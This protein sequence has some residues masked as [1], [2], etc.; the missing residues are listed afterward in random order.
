MPSHPGADTG[1]PAP[2]FL[3]LGPV[4]IYGDDGTPVPVGPPLQRRVLATLILFAGQPCT[5]R[6]L[7]RAIWGERPP[8]DPGGTLRKVAYRLRQSLGPSAS[9]LE[10]PDDGYSYKFSAAK[11]ATDKGQFEDLARRGREAWYQDDFQ[12]AAELLAAAVRLWRDPALADVPATPALVKTGA[13]QR[14]L[15]ARDDVADLWMDARLALGGHHEAIT[16]LRELLDRDPLREHSWAQLITALYRD[17]RPRDAAAAYRAAA[18]VLQDD[19]GTG[20]GPELT[21]LYS[22]ITP[23]R[24]GLLETSA[25]PG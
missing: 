4:T 16:E 13:R 8:A 19:Y 6:W 11:D 1:E 24:A 25:I 14:L 17:G 12:G 15:R 18:A 7:A 3:I 2:R 21:D 22:Q 23:G 9:C 10:S 20:P 5:G